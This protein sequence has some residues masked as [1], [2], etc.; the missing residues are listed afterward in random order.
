MAKTKIQKEEKKRIESSVVRLTRVSRQIIIVILM[1]FILFFIGTFAYMIIE[2]ASISEGLLFTLES[3]AFVR[4]KEVGALHIVN[5]FLIL[6]GVFI[7][8]WVL[9]WIF[10]LF[11][12][13]RLGEYIKEA[14]FMEKLKKMENHYIIC[15]GGRVG[16]YIASALADAKQKYVVIE[17]DENTANE[18]KKKGLNVF[19][20]DA[21]DE[22]VLIQN[23][24]KKA[25]AV[26]PVVLE[27]EKN[28]LITLTARELNPASLIYA[29]VH[30][31]DLISRMKKAGA[32]F[33]IVPEVAGAEKVVQQI[34]K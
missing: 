2:R 25:R 14:K 34:F 26:V 13:G 22:Q 29:R 28:I 20:G 1:L 33:V 10:D 18:L 30:K 3:L 16:G 5:L 15:G 23:G 27:S 8:W 21:T 4:G 17:I 9:W 6:F 12:E 31:K 11:L 19:V 24:I 32:N 7:M